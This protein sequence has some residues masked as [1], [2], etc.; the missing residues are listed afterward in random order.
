MTDANP[1]SHEAARNLAE[2]AK[3]YWEKQGALGVDYELHT[4]SSAASAKSP[5]TQWTYRLTGI[6]P[7]RAM[8]LAW[9]E[10]M[11]PKVKK[12]RR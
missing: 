10:G 4:V 3:A 9:R 1:H 12:T 8:P 2:R 5:Q 6:C 11:R 7:V